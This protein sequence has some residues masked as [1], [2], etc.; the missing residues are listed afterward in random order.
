MKILIC[1][2]FYQS[3]GGEA[4]TVFREKELLGEKGHSVILFSRDNKEINNYGLIQKIN[5]FSDIV[6]SFAGNR[7]NWFIWKTPN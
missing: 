5:F 7:L 4:E 3:R 1:H 2:N 6:F